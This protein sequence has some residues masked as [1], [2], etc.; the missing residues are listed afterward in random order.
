MG[1]PKRIYRCQE[2]RVGQ[3]NQN[4]WLERSCLLK[5]L[6]R[7]SKVGHSGWYYLLKNLSKH[8]HQKQK[9]RNKNKTSAQFPNDVILNQD[10][11]AW[12]LRNV[13]PR[14]V[15]RTSGAVSFKNC[16]SI[17]IIPK[18]GCKLARV[19]WDNFKSTDSL[20]PGCSDWSGGVCGLLTIS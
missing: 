10:L 15:H 5:N 16:S 4:F 17:L 18:F 12:R 14:K 11:F 3:L 2:H 19:M 1:I 7:E 13:Y 8:A 9:N 6:T 20:A